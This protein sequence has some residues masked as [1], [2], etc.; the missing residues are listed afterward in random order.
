MLPVAPVTMAV[1]IFGVCIG[2]GYSKLEMGR[3]LICFY[4]VFSS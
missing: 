3:H 4:R 1:G 2:V